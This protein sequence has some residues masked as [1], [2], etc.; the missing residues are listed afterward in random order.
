[1]VSRNQPLA[2]LRLNAA[3]HQPAMQFAAEIRAAGLPSGRFWR[4]L[5]PL[6]ANLTDRRQLV[7]TVVTKTVGRGGQFESIVSCLVASLVELDR[8]AREALP[9]LG[10]QL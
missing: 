10:D 1:M 8:A 6:A 3:L 4:H 9:E 5:I 2:D 7:E